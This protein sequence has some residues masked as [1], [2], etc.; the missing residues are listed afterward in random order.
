MIARNMLTCA[1]VIALK[2]LASADFFTLTLYSC[3]THTF[4]LIELSPHQVI[5]KDKVPQPNQSNDVYAAQVLFRAKSESQKI[6]NECKARGDKVLWHAKGEVCH[7]CHNRKPLVLT[8][9]CGSHSYCDYHCAV[10]L[11]CDGF[12]FL[13]RSLDSVS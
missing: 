13:C 4:V 2:T 8:F 12:T 9:H 5:P 10:S 11:C 3:A 7:I 1:C 6:V